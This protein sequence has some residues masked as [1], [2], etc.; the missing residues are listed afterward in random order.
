[1]ILMLIGCW[2]SFRYIEGDH[3]LSCLQDKVNPATPQMAQKYAAYPIEHF[4]VQAEKYRPD[5]AVI[6]MYAGDWYLRNNDFI[7]A[8]KAFW[9][10]LELDPV[11]PGAYARLAKIALL[12]GDKA[13]A[14]ELM[15]KAHSLF[16]KSRH[17]KLEKLYG[18]D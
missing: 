18:D 15:L 12:R 6:K 17:Y 4:V 14:E 13:K 9:K 1:M 10:A 16:P 2:S 7:S 8:E 5:A 11:R 3:A